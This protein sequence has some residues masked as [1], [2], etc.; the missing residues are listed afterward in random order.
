MKGLIRT[1]LLFVIIGFNLMNSVYAQSNQTF[2]YCNFEEILAD[3][4]VPQL[5]K[6]IYLNRDWSLS[7]DKDVLSL[8]DSLQARDKKS[9]AFYF[10][11]V[12]K[13]YDK[14]DGYYSEAL[15]SVGKEYVEQHTAEFIAYFDN[16]SCF[17]REDLMTWT[18]IVILELSIVAEE[19]DKRTMVKNYIKYLK[20]N[21]KNCTAFQHANMNAFCVELEKEWK[22][23]L[24]N[25]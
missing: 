9:K 7:S 21:T 22:E 19:N 5:A 14:S 16:S 23:Y 18:K 15:G 13:S 11:A 3:K 24:E 1:S 8:L 6:D 2:N 12:T 20:S 4:R 25:E 17:T 10:K